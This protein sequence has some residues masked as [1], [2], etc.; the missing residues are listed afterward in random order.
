MPANPPRIKEKKLNVEIISAT[1]NPVDLIGYCAGMCYGKDDTSAKRVKFCYKNGHMSVFEH[2]SF[3]A[4]ITGISRACSH[5]LVRH[6]LASY[7]QESQRYTEVDPDRQWYVI[8]PSFRSKEDHLTW[9]RGEMNRAVAAYD[10]A[11]AVGIKPEDARF[12]LPEATK[13]RIA[14]TMNIREAYHFFDLRT[15]KH[16]QWEIRDLANMIIDALRKHSDQWGVLVDLWIDQ[17]GG[18]HE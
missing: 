8:P 6:R 15:A 3:T 18:D 5:Q 16:A 13:T 17:D 4:E 11:L 1:D 9:Y 10:G 7:T 14:M 12:L 2:A